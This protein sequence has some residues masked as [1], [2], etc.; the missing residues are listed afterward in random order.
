MLKGIEKA[1][2]QAK[3]AIESLYDCTCNIYRYEKYKDSVTK[4]TKTGINPIPKHEKQSC[5]VSKQ[6]LSKNNQTDTTNNINYELK[7]FIAPEV[8]IKQGDEIEV[9][10]ALDVKAKYKAGEGFFYYTH[11]EVI[12]NKKDKA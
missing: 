10:N 7:L 5:K 9:T 8:E 1:R 6:S 12:L 3:K 2:K 4:E 11:Q